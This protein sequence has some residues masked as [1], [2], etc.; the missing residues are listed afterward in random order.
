MKFE[1][2]TSFNNNVFANITLGMLL[3]NDVNCYLDDEK[4]ISIDPLFNPTAGGNLMVAESDIDKARE[5][6]KEAEAQYVGSIPCPYCQSCSLIIEDRADK[7]KSF[8]DRMKNRIAYGEEEVHTKI[9]RCE[10]CKK[11]F[12]ELDNV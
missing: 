3:E 11:I 9:Y 6:I 2:L 5:L 7:P 8:W 12:T 10:N 4:R 1:R